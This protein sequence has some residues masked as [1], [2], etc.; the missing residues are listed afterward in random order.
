MRNALKTM[1]DNPALTNAFGAL[2]CALATGFAVYAE[3]QLGLQPCSLCIAQRFAIMVLC[4]IFVVGAALPSACPRRLRRG[5]A[6]AAVA[7]AG[8]GAGFAAWH[9]WLQFSY[10]Y[11]AD[12]QPRLCAIGDCRVPDWVLFGVSAPVW[13]LVGLCVLAALAV[14]AGRSSLAASRHRRLSD[15][16]R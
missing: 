6:L 12:A 7:A 14:F 15:T 4:G 11:I 1:A 9:V 5:C 2:T 3:R 13:V 16:I 10:R 8:T